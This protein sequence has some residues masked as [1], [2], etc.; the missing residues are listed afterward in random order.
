[1]RQSAAPTGV[2][3]PAA[4]AFSSLRE[5]LRHANALLAIVAVRL[6]P[7]YVFLWY[8]PVPDSNMHALAE[9][10]VVVPCVAALVRFVCESGA[11][12]GPPVFREALLGAPPLAILKLLG[13]SLLVTF[14]VVLLSLLNA[15][16]FVGFLLAWSL[17]NLVTDQVVVIEGRALVGAIWRSL[18]LIARLWPA[19]LVVFFV[20]LLPDLANIILYA[21][22]SETAWRELVTRGI[23]V[24]TLPYTTLL[25]TRYYEQLAPLTP[26][27]RRRREK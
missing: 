26:G 8:F 20:V 7:F 12:D 3:S 24:L 25:L 15:G 14:V 22:M 9:T 17:A 23:T 18:E 11:R 1:M 27:P 2:P 6:V 16:L 5:Y 19:S 13:T 21:A 10:V 4:L